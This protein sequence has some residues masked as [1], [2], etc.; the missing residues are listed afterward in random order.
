MN[1]VKY[2][3]RTTDTKH[4]VYH[5]ILF[6]SLWATQLVAEETFRNRNVIRTEILNLTNHTIEKVYSK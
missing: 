1:S 4:N 5:S 3:V 2:Q 6:S